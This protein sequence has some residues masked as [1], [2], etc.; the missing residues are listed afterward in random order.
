MLLVSWRDSPGRMR[1]AR[2]LARPRGEGRVVT[3][4]EGA[5]WRGAGQ[6]AARTVLCARRHPPRGRFC[7][8]GGIRDRARARK[9]AQPAAMERKRP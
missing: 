3:P 2:S 9:G 4:I 7:A 1:R 6:K 8:R 5:G